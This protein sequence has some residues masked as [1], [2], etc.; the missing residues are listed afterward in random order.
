[1]VNQKFRTV[2]MTLRQEEYDLV[3]ER[4]AKVSLPK[5][6]Y[7]RAVLRQHLAETYDP[8]EEP[9]RSPRV[10]TNRRTS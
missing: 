6:T 9:I 5:A 4:A 10:I 3:T 1:V 2:Q 8:M 7:C